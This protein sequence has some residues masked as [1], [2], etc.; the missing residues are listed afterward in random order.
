LKDSFDFVGTAADL[1][2]RMAQLNDNWLRE[3]PLYSWNGNNCQMYAQ[4]VLAALLGMRIATQNS[5]HGD[6]MV[7]VASKAVMISAIGV[8]VSAALLFAGRLV[9]GKH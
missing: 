4:D 1:H 6:A 5:T 7:S 3:H 8:V 9:K 2:H